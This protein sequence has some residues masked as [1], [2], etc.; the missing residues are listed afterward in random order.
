MPFLQLKIGCKNV[1][2][3]FDLEFKDTLANHRI[4]VN[5]GEAIKA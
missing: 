4:T 1:Q 5:E 2:K 3:Y